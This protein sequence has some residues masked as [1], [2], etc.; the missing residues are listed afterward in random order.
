MGKSSPRSFVQTKR[1]ED[2]TYLKTLLECLSW[3]IYKRSCSFI[4]SGHDYFFLEKI[5]GFLLNDHFRWE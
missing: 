4:D 3:D 2:C 5:V 1:S